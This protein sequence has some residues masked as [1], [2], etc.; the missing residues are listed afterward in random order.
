MT[1]ELYAFYESTVKAVASKIG[2]TYQGYTSLED[3]EQE[4]WVWIFQDQQNFTRYMNDAGSAYL[5]LQ[6]R[7]HTYCESQRTA[8]LGIIEPSYALY[9]PRAV[10]ELLQDCFDYEDW[11]SF[12]NKGDSQPKAKRLEA[13]SDRLAMLVDVKTATGKLSDR[14]YNIII[15]RFKYKYDDE[16]MADM[17][18]IAPTSVKMT[19]SR[20]VKALTDLLNPTDTTH[21]HVE[22]RKVKS[23]AAARAELDNSW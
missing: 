19:V 13:T 20:A 7:A 8:S 15:G 17:L 21:G 9:S 16:Q 10:R 4:L 11:Q 3:V 6:R 22:R 5:A 12:A 23:N 14:D 2:R 18:E 1:E